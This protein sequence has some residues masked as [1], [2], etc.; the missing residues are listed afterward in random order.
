[1]A[2]QTT[3]E[4]VVTNPTSDAFVGIWDSYHSIC[5]RAD[6]RP[7][8]QDALEHLS[9]I[10]LR[11]LLS[12]IL[13]VLQDLPQAQSK[14][15]LVRLRVAVRQL[16]ISLEQ[17]PIGFDPDGVKDLLKTV[18]ADNP[19][20]GLLWE[21]AASCSRPPDNE[22]RGAIPEDSRQFFLN[23]LPSV[24]QQHHLDR[25]KRLTK[26]LFHSLEYPRFDAKDSIVALLRDN[27]NSK[28]K[29]LW[30]KCAKWAIPVCMV[31]RQLATEMRMAVE[32]VESGKWE[33]SVVIDALETLRF[34][35][36]DFYGPL[37]RLLADFCRAKKGEKYSNSIKLEPPD[38]LETFGQVGKFCIQSITDAEMA[39]GHLVLHW[40]KERDCLDGSPLNLKSS[41]LFAAFVAAPAASKVPAATFTELVIRQQ[42]GIQRRSIV[43]TL[44]GKNLVPS[45]KHISALLSALKD[46]RSKYPLAANSGVPRT[47][48]IVLDQQTG[49]ATTGATQ[50]A[51]HDDFPWLKTIAKQIHPL[52]LGGTFRQAI[53]LCSDN[54]AQLIQEALT[55]TAGQRAPDLGDDLVDSIYSEF[56]TATKEATELVRKPRV[57]KP[58]PAPDL[59]LQEWYSH[60]ISSFSAPL[61]EGY[62]AIPGPG[63]TVF[64]WAI[65]PDSF[66]HHPPCLRCQR[67]YSQWSLY[68]RPDD[69]EGK[70][71]ALENLHARDALGYNA[72]N[73]TCT[74]C[75]E[76][77]AAAKIYLL[78]NARLSLEEMG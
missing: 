73:D 62:K 38:R 63:N 30:L 54:V 14:Y 12:S 78:R 24:E 60:W 25:W 37:A 36:D 46:K 28:N 33:D 65:R 56:M 34:S 50:P 40:G 27:N 19:D 74:Y 22:T 31:L 29:Q 41:S 10:D 58:V 76:S 64:C 8:D 7:D 53:H 5:K 16:Q 9:P 72:K 44:D 42:V 71:V 17:D 55:K 3:L 47:L 51:Y 49:I 23:Q 57:D 21:Q 66:E 6:V 18:F 67:I 20:Y 45:T 68:G 48:T 75:A 13:S 35:I 52:R 2:D 77:V 15:N 26:D 69:L 43:T 4:P 1:M 61:S 70:R 39:F 59:P 11:E 32:L